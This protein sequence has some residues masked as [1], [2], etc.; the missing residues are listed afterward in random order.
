MLHLGREAAVSTIELRLS[1]NLKNQSFVWRTVRWIRS[2]I[3]LAELC[4]GTS[5]RP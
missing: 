1:S 5:Q 3:A 2:L 4:L